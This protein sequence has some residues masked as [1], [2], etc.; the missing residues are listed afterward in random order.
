M[1]NE[2][3]LKLRIAPADAASLRHIPAV[4]AATVGKPVTRKL[5]SIYYDTPDLQ[6]LD[7]DVSLRVRHMSGGWFQ[8]VKGK[9]KALAGLHQRMEWED[10]IAAGHPDFSK[11]TDPAL[12]RIFDN[13]ALRAALT[14]IFLTTVK[15]TE[16]QL[17]MPDGS[18]IEMALDMGRLEACGK[19]EP[20]NEV[21]LELKHGHAARLFELALELQAQVP[22][23]IENVSKAQRGYGYY[24][25]APLQVVKAKMPTLE[26]SMRAHEAFRHIGWE[27]LTQL[28]GNQDM[29]LHGSDPEG[30]HQMR[31]ALRRLRSAMG[32]FRAVIDPQQRAAIIEELRWITGMMG[33]TRDLDVFITETLPRIIEQ[34][35]NHPGLLALRDKAIAAQ[36]E[37]CA[38]AHAAIQSQ[39]YQRL[40]LTLGALLE[41]E[42]ASAPLRN[43]TEIAEAMLRKRNKQLR[44]HGRLLQE[45]NDE[46]RHLA[47]IAG[48]KLRYA[49]EFFACLYPHD[50][51]QPFLQH[52][53]DLQN[54]LGTL[55]DIAVTSNLIL[56]LAG[57]R[58]TKGLDE[59]L[60]IFSGWNGCHAMH[61][62]AHMDEVWRAFAV[63]KPFWH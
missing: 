26:S 53:E 19:S 39:R 34:L 6:L 7:A 24:R 60:H 4:T 33:A 45:A 36:A 58:P 37:A 8:A 48:K 49:T 29:V 52:L 47:R 3:E 42:P 12:T 18:Q 16:W 10:V 63:Q 13:D 21:E 43:V 30:V 51:S 11:I 61:K 2:V 50:K 28:Q 54:V 59:A 62:L 5:V 56:R 15:R 35:D 25:P 22:L 32:L 20:I 23:H 31:V 27:C 55:N 9:G 57:P 17:A 1:S 44:R 41:N 40:L 38:E 46:E 14:P